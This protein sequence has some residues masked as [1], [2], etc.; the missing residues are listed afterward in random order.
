MKNNKK[1]MNI[2]LDYGANIFL[3]SKYGDAMAD[4]LKNDWE[5][6]ITIYVKKG[7]DT[8]ASFSSNVRL[9][10]PDGYFKFPFHAVCAKGWTDTVKLMIENGANVN[11]YCSKSFLLLYTSYHG[12]LEVVKLLVENGARINMKGYN[13]TTSLMAAA[14][15]K[16]K[17]VVKY[18]IDQGAEIRHTTVEGQN[19]LHHAV[20][21]G[22]LSI[23]NTILLKGSYSDAELGSVL[24]SAASENNLLLIQMLLRAGADINYKN[25]G[26]QL[27]RYACNK[28]NIE[29]L[30]VL[31]EGGADV[32]G[33]L[34][35]SGGILNA[36]L[37]YPDRLTARAMVNLLLDYRA[38]VNRVSTDVHF[39]RGSSSFLIACNYG[40]YDVVNRMIAQR[41]F[42]NT[43]YGYN[44]TAILLASRAGHLDIVKLLLA[45]GAVT[46]IYSRYDGTALAAAIEK[47]YYDIA[48]IL[49]EAGADIDRLRIKDRFDTALQAL[50]Y[51]KNYTL[52]TQLIEERIQDAINAPHYHA[53]FLKACEGENLELV[54]TFVKYEIDVRKVDLN[55]KTCLHYAAKSG[56][57]ELV[58]FLGK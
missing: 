55:Y 15:R 19:V 2:L 39:Y 10:N 41:P 18:L 57:L 9:K 21:N 34:E 8:N 53:S 30:K 17:H 43:I 29:M 38:D 22:W 16:H 20:A 50:I 12:R 33:V 11:S 48:R 28:G 31:L 56:S 35:Y 3:Q 24:Q 27:L 36:A 54:K 14:S 47:G 45:N 23:T 6:I 7:Y 49:I 32:N 4:M 26:T 25:Q 5:D 52:A 13:G 37:H 46:D 44:Y 1:I 58:D 42:I 51:K 40:W